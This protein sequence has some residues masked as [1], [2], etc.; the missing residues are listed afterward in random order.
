MSNTLTPIEL[1]TYLTKYG[2]DPVAGLFV[3]NRTKPRGHIAFSC[4]GEMNTA[5]SILVP[6]TFIPIDL[7][8]KVPR[9]KLLD[10]SAFRR[11]LANGALAIVDNDEVSALFQ[12][13]KLARDEHAKIHNITTSHVED[14]DIEKEAQAFTDDDASS[15]FIQ[16]LITRSTAGE[17]AESVA[18]MLLSKLDTVTKDDVTLLANTVSDSKL[19]EKCIEIIKELM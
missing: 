14:Y 18:D 16:E 15:E 4:L 13:S 7:T 9:Q 5:Q 11:Q 17:D 3:I 10:S 12:K 6:A 8:T 1:S 19:K 2:K